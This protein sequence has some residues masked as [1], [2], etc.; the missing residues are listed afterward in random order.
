MG[1]VRGRAAQW[2][3]STLVGDMTAHV[4][5]RTD[6]RSLSCPVARASL[7]SPELVRP[8]NKWLHRRRI[9]HPSDIPR[10]LLDWGPS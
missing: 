6:G 8:E 5:G 2:R 1:V 7:L 10:T 4:P 3:H 9:A